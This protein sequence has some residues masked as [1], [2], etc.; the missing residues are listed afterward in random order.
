[1]NIP[2]AFYIFIIAVFLNSCV[3][4]HKGPS[5]VPRDDSSFTEW[6]D[7]LEVNSPHLKGVKDSV[8]FIRKADKSHFK[9]VDSNKIETLALSSNSK[10]TVEIEGY[11]TPKILWWGNNLVVTNYKIISTA[12][13][14][15]LHPKHRT[16]RTDSGNGYMSRI[17]SGDR[18]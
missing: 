18:L 8:H 12:E 16:R 6:V 5:T 3:T 2:L 11:I 1:M 10:L 9:I 15:K 4:L 7:T 13:D 14:D 17:S